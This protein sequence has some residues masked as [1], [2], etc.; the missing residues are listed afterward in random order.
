MSLS[1]LS[2]FK[3][4]DFASKADASEELSSDMITTVCK[5]HTSE[6]IAK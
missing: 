6:K 2:T 5:Q 1:K 3:V 4:T